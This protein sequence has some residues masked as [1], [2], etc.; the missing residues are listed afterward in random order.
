MLA[1]SPVIIQSSYLENVNRHPA[2][3]STSTQTNVAWGSFSNDVPHA[4]EF[5]G[6]QT[7]VIDEKGD[8]QL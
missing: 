5:L 8:S 4:R 1:E 6:S 2:G 7:E 3:C